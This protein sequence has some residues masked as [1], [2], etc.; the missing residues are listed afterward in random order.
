MTTSPTWR[1]RVF[2]ALATAVVGLSIAVGAATPASAHAVADPCTAKAVFIGVRGTGAPAGTKAT[3][4][5]N[6]WTSGGHGLVAGL[7][8]HFASKKQYP[9]Y[10]ES[11]AYPA[12]SDYQ[13]SVAAGAKKL[14]AELSW[15][16]T[17][18][19]GTA[20]VVLAGHSQGADVVLDALSRLTDPKLKRMVTAVAVFGDPTFVANQKYNAAG[21]GTRHGMMPR[22]SQERTVL[23][24]YRLSFQG[25]D[26]TRL[27]SFCSAG[28]WACQGAA[29]NS[30]SAAIH[31]GYKT[32][33]AAGWI[34]SIVYRSR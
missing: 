18:C 2:G 31:N 7:A 16:N 34:E 9:M 33:S 8:G 14:T 11:L 5:G 22:S 23:N 28:D 1:R 17:R 30:R 10:I 32:A 3:A 15:L 12:S 27:R 21:S 6:A 19:K 25:A 24:T 13:A 26:Y 20:R 29:Y 4:S